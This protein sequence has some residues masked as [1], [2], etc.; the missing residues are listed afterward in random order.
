M[1]EN[2]IP[3]TNTVTLRGTLTSLSDCKTSRDGHIYHVARMQVMRLSTTFDHITLVI[4]HNLTKDLTPTSHVSITG[5]LCAS[6]NKNLPRHNKTRVWVRVDTIELQTY[7]DIDAIDDVNLVTLTTTFYDVPKT[8]HTPQGKL[9]ADGFIYIR[10]RVYIPAIAWG[11]TAIQL[12]QMPVTVP[13]TPI[14]LQARL[15]S[16]TYECLND[17]GEVGTYET[18]EVCIQKILTKEDGNN[19]S[20][21]ITEEIK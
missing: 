8:R 2:Q 9:I 3:L 17:D 21:I 10:P 1:H 20:S 19:P 7:D 18:V 11:Q 13:P 12:S 15:Q 14:K 4:P 16:R 6:Y 5:T